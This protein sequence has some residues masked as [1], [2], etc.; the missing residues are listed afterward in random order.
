MK[1]IDD[2][3]AL[4]NKKQ[5]WLTKAELAAKET[6]EEYD[7]ILI[8]SRDADLRMT[9]GPEKVRDVVCKD[10]MELC[11]CYYERDVMTFCM[12]TDNA[13]ERSGKEGMAGSREVSIL[14]VKKT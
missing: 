6:K 12:L 3:Q 4:L 14:F 8:E 11:M 9:Y 7:T 13:R 10:T 5:D 1:Q 2:R